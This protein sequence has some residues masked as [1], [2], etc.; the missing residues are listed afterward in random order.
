M[1]LDVY[2]Y[3]PE[4]QE[5]CQCPHCDNL[6]S[7]AVKEEFFTDNITHN[8]GKMAQAVDLYKPLWR[9]EE[10]GVTTAGQLIPLLEVGMDRLAKEVDELEKLNPPNGWGDHRGLLDFVVRYLSACREYPNA[11]ITVSR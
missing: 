10:I 11:T 8:L 6:H 5:K 7:H 9:P 4:S 2:I 3:G 1:S